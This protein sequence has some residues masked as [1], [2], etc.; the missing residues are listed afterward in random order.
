MSDI[1]KID[2]NLREGKILIEAPES[3]LNT[4]F[5]KVDHIFNKF[6]GQIKPFEQPGNPKEE[7][8]ASDTEQSDVNTGKKRSSKSRPKNI[9]TVDLKL[10]REQWEA[11]RTFY[12]QKS[13]HN[14][15]ST[16]LVVMYWLIKNTERKSVSDQEIL[17]GIKVVEGAIPKRLESVIANLKIG[18]Y[19]LSDKEDKEKFILHH[20]GENFVENKLPK[21]EAKESK[22]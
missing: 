2:I 3:A 21:K 15:N 18:S 19:V 11:F 10:S 22:K 13:P 14:Q 17:S 4:A 7:Q 12:N 1:V 8:Y 5:E 9:P 16:V 6:S 20:L